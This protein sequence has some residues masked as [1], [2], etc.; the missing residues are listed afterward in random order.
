MAASERRSTRVCCR[1]PAPE[2]AVLHAG[3][4]L[5]AGFAGVAAAG[6]CWKHGC[7]CH[8]GGGRL[9]YARTTL[10]GVSSVGPTLLGV[11]SV[12][13]ASHE[14]NSCPQQARAALRPSST[15]RQTP[16]PSALC[17]G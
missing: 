16:R 17:G 13:A 5:C 7:R 12:A 11:S 15:A 10:L 1:P 9:S 4:W 8:P 14:A 3:R 6:T 2:P